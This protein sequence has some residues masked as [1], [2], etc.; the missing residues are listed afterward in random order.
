MKMTSILAGMATAAFT[1]ALLDDPDGLAA[2]AARLPHFDARICALPDPA[3]AAAM[4][5]WRGQDARRNGIAQ[6]AQA[7]F[8]HR[9]LQGR[10][11]SRLLE[12]LA[13]AGISPS[14]Y[15]EAARHGMLLRR[16]SRLRRLTEAERARLPAAHLPPEDMEVMRRE[17]EAYS[18]ASPDRIANLEAVLF[19]E[20]AIVSTS[21]HSTRSRN[22]RLV[23]Q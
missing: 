12:M 16:M 22:A 13:Q 14:D 9:D 19:A 21:A 6:I 7:H 10:S 1:R 18:E 2:W 3:A 5:A 20:A 11:V 15:P 8:S 23:P 4:F 17:T